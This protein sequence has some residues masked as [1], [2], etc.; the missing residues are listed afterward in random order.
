VLLKSQATRRGEVTLC[1]I[2]VVF[3]SATSEFGNVATLGNRRG[4]EVLPKALDS[5]DS[6]PFG[7]IG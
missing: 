4:D 3:R 6:D 1:N 2:F 5:A 7:L